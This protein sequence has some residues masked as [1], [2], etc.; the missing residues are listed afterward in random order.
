[1]IDRRKILGAAAA[2][3]GIGGAAWAAPGAKAPPPR[4]LTGVWTNGW[5]TWLE[6]AKEFKALVVTPAEAEAFEGP[7]VERRSARPA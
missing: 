1:M 2:V 6:R 4:D 7:R 3:A 5:Y